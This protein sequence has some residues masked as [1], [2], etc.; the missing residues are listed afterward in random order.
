MSWWCW[1]VAAAVAANSWC[2]ARA[3]PGPSGT[4][5][6]VQAG[7][8]YAC[9]AGA[10]CGAIEPNGPCTSPRWWWA[11]LPTPSSYGSCTYPS[12]AST[13]G[14]MVMPPSTPG[15]TSPSAAIGGT[16]PMKGI[17][18]TSMVY[19]SAWKNEEQKPKEQRPKANENKPV[20]TE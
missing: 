20:M 10:G 1:V 16:S 7:L 2:I 8:D 17:W 6:L 12:S 13:V 14:G 4:T 19:R 11:T 18:F 9:G 15:A 3:S 5:G